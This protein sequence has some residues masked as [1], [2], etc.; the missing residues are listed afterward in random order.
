M[1]EDHMK[2]EQLMPGY[3]EQI[4]AE[5]QMILF[6]SPH[7]N[8]TNTRTLIPHMKKLAD[9]P[10]NHL[11]HVIADSYYGSE[12]KQQAYFTMTAYN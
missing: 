6:Y 11:K 7:Q 9:S 4:S 8:P 12:K 3:N 2:N 1:K 5:N 10:I